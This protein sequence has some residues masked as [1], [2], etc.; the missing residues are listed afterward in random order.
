MYYISNSPYSTKKIGRAIAE[1]VLKEKKGDKAFIIALSGEL[2]GGK[3]TFVQGFASFFDIKEKIVSPTFVI[4]KRYKI[5]KGRYRNLYHI[6]CYRLSK[7]KDLIDLG[8]SEIL[9]NPFNILVVEWA[10]RLKDIFK[11]ALWL[12]FFV[13]G[14]QKR[15]I[16]VE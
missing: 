11:D 2:G 6:D 10:D 3:T 12:K 13:I 4:I 7:K 16:V 8:I 15:K 14:K 9:N 5:K 1:K